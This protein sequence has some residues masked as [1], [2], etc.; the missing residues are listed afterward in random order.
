MPLHLNFYHEIE[1]QKAASRRDPLKIAAY[2][3]IGIV[4]IF[5]G[6]YLLE[7]GK[8]AA[9]ASQMSRL[10]SEFDKIDP[11]ARDA[12]KREEAMKQT[13]ETSERFVK[14][15]EGRFYWAPMMEEVIKIVP[16]E[17][18][19]TKM[20]GTVQGEGAKKAVINFDGIAAG[21]D[22]RRVAEDL[23]QA[24]VE[25][26]G[27]KFQNVTASFRQLED[28]TDVVTLDGKN[29]STA[30]FGIALSLQMGEETPATPPPAGGHTK[31]RG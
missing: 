19:V 28:S 23:R 10:K 8:Y 14:A 7:L 12:A 27:K 3:L 31:K 9:S 18:Q 22:P 20:T 30:V 25:N 17:V 13:F 5:A 1:S 2:I 29:L 21:T 11:G 26:F 16:R 15:I 4:A 24:L 6:M